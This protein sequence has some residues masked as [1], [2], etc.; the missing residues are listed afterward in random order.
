MRVLLIKA[1]VQLGQNL[2]RALKAAHY[3]VDWIRDGSAAC[4]TIEA[5]RYAAVLLD[6]RVP[7]I[8]GIAML[9][10]LRAAGHSVPVLTLTAPDDLDARVRSLD[11]GAD[12]CLLSP[13]D[14]REL[15]A[16]LRAVLRRRAGSA[17][18]RIGNE[19]LGLDLEQ[20]TLKREVERRHK[21]GSVRFVLLVLTLI[22]TAVIVTIVMFRTLSLLLG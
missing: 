10:A 9:G 3:T 1:D 18:S 15:L 5:T 20:R 11:T 7:G 22:L 12:D 4:R 19:T 17:T 6:L 2:F 8:D 13:V 14:G 21:R 16:R